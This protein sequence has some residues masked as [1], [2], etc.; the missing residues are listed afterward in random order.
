MFAFLRHKYAVFSLNKGE[1]WFAAL[2]S[3]AILK[4]QNY[5]REMITRPIFSLVM[6]WKISYGGFSV[7]YYLVHDEQNYN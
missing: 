5:L 2:T 6:I 3:I 1:N 7:S 4:T